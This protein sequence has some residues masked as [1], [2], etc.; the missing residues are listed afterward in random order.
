MPFVL[1]ESNITVEKS[2][3]RDGKA[4]PSG[5]ELLIIVQ[6]MFESFFEYYAIV[7]ELI[8]EFPNKRILLFNTPG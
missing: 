2:K 1:F 5:I 8:N 3:S 7:A 4:S 6:D